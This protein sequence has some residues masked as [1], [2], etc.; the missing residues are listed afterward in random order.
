MTATLDEL[1]ITFVEH[2]CEEDVKW[3]IQEG[4]SPDAREGDAKG[5]E[6]WK[7]LYQPER[8]LCHDDP[9]GECGQRRTRITLQPNVE[10]VRLLLAYGARVTD[11][12]LDAALENP[13]PEFLRT[14]ESH[15]VSPIP[16]P[17]LRG[18]GPLELTN[19]ALTDEVRELNSHAAT[20][21]EKARDAE[22]A[23]PAQP[24]P[25]TSVRRVMFAIAD[26]A[27]KIADK[28]SFVTGDGIFVN[29]AY[30]N[31][32]GSGFH[33]STKT[34]GHFPLSHLTLDPP[35]FG[36]FHSILNA[37]MPIASRLDS[38][39]QFTHCGAPTVSGPLR[40]VRERVGGVQAEV[41]RQSGGGT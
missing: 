18:P 21:E 12:E 5:E 39:P 16:C 30:A 20:A 6:Q 13:D 41:Q 27:H 2:W 19:T 23:A 4:A 10:I 26:N 37:P 3:L 38:L 11:I 34:S 9:P 15:Q 7:T 28:I 40:E 14:L 29:F 22:N 25:P 31:G 24:R 1:L 17:A 32:W 35:P 8:G 33:T 36:A